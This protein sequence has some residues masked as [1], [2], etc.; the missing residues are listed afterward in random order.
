MSAMSEIARLP[1][2]QRD[3]L[4]GSA[5]GGLGRAELAAAMGLSEGAVRQL[6]HRARATVRTAVTAI[7]PWPLANWLAAMPG[8]PGG[9]P[10]VVA[11][12]GA[13]SGGG[14]AV[15]LG[16][17]LVTGAV[18][19]GVAVAPGSHHPRAHTSRAAVAPAPQQ[20]N[21]HV[22]A[23]RVLPA[24]RP[25]NVGRIGEG[26]RHHGGERGD[27]HGGRGETHDRDVRGDSRSREGPSTRA[28]GS[29]DRSVTTRASSRGDHGGGDRSSDGSSHGGSSD[30][31]SPGGSSDDSSHGGDD[32]GH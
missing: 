11:A 16:A 3:A 31:S 5:L 22:A 9:T 29:D 25:R 6:V 12:A 7:T 32:S 19:T 1:E 10:E 13:L 28:S 24:A 30:G 18:A 23:S 26:E 27:S 4:V 2:R 21:V 8:G 17:L 14:I 20:T 15:K